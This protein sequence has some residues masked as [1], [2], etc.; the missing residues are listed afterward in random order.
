MPA[1]SANRYNPNPITKLIV[2][3]ILGLTAI[4]QLNYI[5]SISIVIFISI[6]YILNVFIK[7]AI[8]GMILFA[9][10]LHLP[11]F[12]ALDKLPMIIKIILSFVIIIK[13]FFIP[14]YAGKFLI[15]SS[16]VGSIISSMDKLRI[17]SAFSIPIAVM[18][19]FFPSF[20]EERK[21]IKLAMKIRGISFKNPIKY[22][23]YVMV[24]LLVISSN[25]ADDIAKAAEVKCIEN[26]IK[27]TRYIEI[28][29]KPVDF[30]YILGTMII[31]AGGWLC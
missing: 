31:V 14:F 8:K 24:P 28:G 2:V 27:K 17:P 23:E 15:K 21:N 4:H 25:I 19:R 1:F 3:F 10:V 29:I 7:D 20:R 6:F 11:N 30:F 22:I 13:F 5:A 18:F 9:I 26:P 16:D 12:D